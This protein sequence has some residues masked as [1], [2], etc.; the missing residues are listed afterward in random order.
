MAKEIIMAAEIEREENKRIRNR[1]LAMIIPITIE[2]ILQ[3]MTGFVSMAMIG[4]IDAIAV[5]ALGIS[6]RIT[7]IIWALFNGIATGVTVFVAQ[8]YGSNNR[9]KI[10]KVAIQSLMASV[11]LVVILQQIIFW[12]ASNILKIFD[13][14][15]V[16]LQ[17]GTMYLKISSWGLPFITI[18]LIVAGILHGVGNTKTP[19]QIVLIMN[20]M[21]IFFSYILIFGKFG[22]SPLK[23][24][25]AAI[26][27]VLAQIIAAFLGIWVLFGKDG[28]L[29]NHFN[30][31][32]L[33]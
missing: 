16:L 4:R 20:I 15:D 10:K 18:V 11:I 17:N 2:N 32:L 26:S 1:I 24:K 14:N 13:P 3:M 6:N 27:I 12:N 5:G 9:E 7:Q 31:I 33:N 28:I 29:S 23:L 19:M 22:I 8:A 25:G 21:N 30:K